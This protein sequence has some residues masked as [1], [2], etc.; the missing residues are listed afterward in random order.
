[1]KLIE[2]NPAEPDRATI[3]QAASILEEG[4]LIIFPTETVYGLAALV[5]NKPAVGKL[6]QL[7]NRSLDK[8]LTLHIANF[9][10]VEEV[11]DEIPQCARRLM[12][13]YWPGPL[14]IIM[15]ATDGKKVGFRM[16]SNSIAREIIMATTGL[17]G[18]SSAN[19]SGVAPPLTVSDIAQPLLDDV[20]LVIDGGRT[21][22][23]GASTIV[24]VSDGSLVILREG[25]IRL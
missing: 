10:T 11:I 2:L 19:L 1:M 8:P 25:P 6:Y 3:E 14:T 20:D 12:E 24:D 18:A 13:Q 9:A 15:K 21:E 17:I 22:Y 16:P 7:K 5:D 23:E 4:G